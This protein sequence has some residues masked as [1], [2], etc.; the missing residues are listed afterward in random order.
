[1]E[2][3]QADLTPIAK[4]L[5]SMMIQLESMHELITDIA[6]IIGRG[7]ELAITKAGELEERGYIDFATA[8]I[9]VV[10]RIVTNFSKED[11]EALGDN[12]V[13]MLGLVKD[14]TQ[15][16]M[17]A[18]ADRL[19]DAVRRQAQTAEL[20]PE[21][22]PSLISLVGKMRDP[23]IRM[24]L[25]RALNTFK[26]VSASETAV[27]TDIANGTTTKTSTDDNMGGA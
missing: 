7:V 24:G 26:A 9:G 17:L 1:M 21:K 20:E 11:V 2:E 14:L 5:D 10:D 3:L 19:L 12:V 18:V 13:H 6:P 4:L 8:G 15:P 27:A 25:A 23:E 16:E 22:P